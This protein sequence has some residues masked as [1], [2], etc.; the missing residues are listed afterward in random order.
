M[1]WNAPLP[2][3]RAWKNTFHFGILY[4]KI[5]ST[6]PKYLMCFGDIWSYIVQRVVGGRDTYEAPEMRCDDRVQN[7]DILLEFCGGAHG[8]CMKCTL[9]WS[10]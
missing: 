1:Y 8:M 7:D 3:S 6:Y 10:T 2:H 5:V 9:T 4:V